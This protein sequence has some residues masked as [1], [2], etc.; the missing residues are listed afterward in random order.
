M[1]LLL[2]ALTGCSGGSS[3]ASVAPNPGPPT[4][5]LVSDSGYP[6]PLPPARSSGDHGSRLHAASP[7]ADSDTLRILTGAR[8]PGRD[9]TW[10]LWVAGARI[11][12][13]TPSRSVPADAFQVDTTDQW[14]VPGVIDSH[15]HLAY[16]PLVQQMA[17]G[18]VV[19]AVDQAAPTTFFDTDFSP[20][21]VMGAGPMV[22]AVSG[23][24]T[25]SWGAGGY[26]LEVADPAAAVEAVTTLHAL[27]AAL[28]KLPVTL[29][30]Q[31]TEATMLAAVGQAHALDLR[32]SSHALGDAEAALAAQVGADVLAHTPV[33]PLSPTTVAAWSNRA[34]ITSLRAFGGSATAVANLVSLRE[35]G[36]LVLYGTDFGNTQS[37]GVDYKE[38]ELLLAA[39][40]DAPA[41]LRAATQAP[42]EFWGFDDLGKLEPGR[43]ATFLVLSADPHQDPLALASPS[44]VWIDGELVSGVGP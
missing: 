29:G 35:A 6:H 13:L 42:A 11:A 10:D 38:L 9:G 4:P 20:L 23:Y 21:R 8:L 3:P 7:G 40:L 25:Q 26:G 37:P 30:P 19:A 32:V 1:A 36:A 41:I 15:V 28:I 27:G 24:P 34:V 17:E 44:Q 14:L 43:S 16:L 31:L 5:T 33:G 39:G 22:T 2:V 12:R 18:G